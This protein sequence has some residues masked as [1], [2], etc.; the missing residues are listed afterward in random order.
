M[1]IMIIYFW[2]VFGWGVGWRVAKFVWMTS[3]V[4]FSILDDWLSS[5]RNISVIGGTKRPGKGNN[6]I[7]VIYLALIIV[8]RLVLSTEW[9][10]KGILNTLSSQ[11]CAARVR[12]IA[13]VQRGRPGK[14]RHQELDI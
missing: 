6:T 9:Y 12:F 11:L 5:G 14:R 4:C 7:G 1:I 2:L 10:M 3:N 8:G 13:I